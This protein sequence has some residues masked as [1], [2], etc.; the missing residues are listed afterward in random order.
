M[1]SRLSSDLS[2]LI[3]SNE[4]DCHSNSRFHS[5]RDE[6]LPAIEDQLLDLYFRSQ[7]DPWM[8]EKIAEYC[9][10]YQHLKH[11]TPEYLDR[12]AQLQLF[13]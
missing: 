6:Y 9:T 8:R 3:T 12:V 4:R 1:W 7:N 5:I 13:L 11:I 10:Y 2:E